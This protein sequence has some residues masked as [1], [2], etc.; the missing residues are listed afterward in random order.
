MILMAGSVMMMSSMFEFFN[1]ILLKAII[2][3]FVLDLASLFYVLIC[4]NSINLVKLCIDCSN[5]I[6]R[7][8]LI[9]IMF[10]DG[11]DEF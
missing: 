6:D 4:S 11:F 3:I 9:I 10:G 8:I 5:L 7:P 2:L 1:L